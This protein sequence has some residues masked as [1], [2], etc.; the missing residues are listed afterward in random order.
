MIANAYRLLEPGGVF[1]WKSQVRRPRWK[2][3]VTYA[4]EWLM[5]HF[6]PTRGVTLCFMDTDESLAV[7]RS[8]GFQAEARP[9]P[10]WRPYPD[11]LFIAV[12]PQGSP[13]DARSPREPAHRQLPPGSG[14]PARGTGHRG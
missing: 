2:Y 13:D 11:V 14:R 3:A 8:A 6:G 1:L 12:K 5:T 9:L 10:S 7:L 4:Q